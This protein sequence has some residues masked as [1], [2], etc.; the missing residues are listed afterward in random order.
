MGTFFIIITCAIATLVIIMK[1]YNITL[2]KESVEFDTDS[3]K[4]RDN[5]IGNDEEQ[6]IYIGNL[7]FK[8]SIKTK[9][10]FSYIVFNVETTGNK[11]SAFKSLNNYPKI[12]SFSWIK[13]D[14]SDCIISA[15]N[16]IIKTESQGTDIKT[17]LADF[18]NDIEDVEFLYAY[19]MKFHYRAVLSELYRNN[20]KS[21]LIKSKKRHT[22][23]IRTFSLPPSDKYKW[24]RR[25]TLSECYSF[26]YSYPQIKKDNIHQPLYKTA[27]CGKI[28]HGIFLYI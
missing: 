15:K 24:F 23:K 17:V 12:V 21:D 3:E 5:N 18:L 1:L 20:F 7:L 27:L 9:Y 2:Y 22:I 19:N 28:L 10:E 16:Y 14:D 11:L 26:L 13:F 8:K 6:D 25:L 4:I